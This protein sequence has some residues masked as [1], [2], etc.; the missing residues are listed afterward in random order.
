M[1]N[2]NI[3]LKGICFCDNHRLSDHG[4]VSPMMAMKHIS[5]RYILAV[6]VFTAFALADAHPAR[7]ATRYVDNAAN[8]SNNGTSWTNAWTSL[9]AITGVT[10]GDTVYIS[11]GT[12]SKTYS[13]NWTLSPGSSGSNRVTY[14]IGQE[15]G[16]IGTA[17]FSGIITLGNYTVLDGEYSG[18]RRFQLDNEVRGY[19][20]HYTKVT[21]CTVNA[22]WNYNGD[23][24]YFEISYCYWNTLD[25]DHAI[26]FNGPTQ[27]TW[28]ANSIHHNTFRLAHDTDGSGYGTDGLQNLSSTSIY[29]NTFEGVLKAGA[30]GN[31]QDG[32]QTGENYIK[33]YNNT[34]INITNYAFFFEGS[35]GAHDVQVYN[36]VF[37]FTET[38]LSGGYQ[39][40]IA[41]GEG[42]AC[43][44]APG[45]YTNFIVANNTV[46]DK[47]GLGI[48]LI[49][50]GQ[51]GCSDSWD[52]STIVRNNFVYS[53]SGQGIDLDS[54]IPTSA[55]NKSSSSGATN[56]F[57]D[58]ANNDFHLKSTDTVLKDQGVNTVSSYFST[59]KDG[60]SRPQGSVWDIGAYEF[61]A[62]SSDTTPP[63][64]SI[65]SPTSGSIVSGTITVS[66]NASDNVGVT[67]VQFKLDGSNLGA[68][69][70]SS[71]YSITWNTASA[72]NGS[73][74]L[75]AVARD[76]SNNQTT[77]SGITVTVSNA[78]DTQA[79]T[80]PANLT[81]TAIS[82]TQINLSWTASTDNVGVT[83]Y[84]IYRCQG[85]GC[86]PSTQTG[87]SG[88]TSY[89]DTGL[90]GNTTY[91]YSVSAYDATG[92]ESAKSSTTFATTQT[93]P[94]IFSLGETSILSI[95]DSG[96]ANLLI[97][98]SATLSQ[99]GTIL[100]LSFYVTTAAGKLRLGVY[101]SSGPNGG[102]GVK[103]AETNEITPTT[104]WNTANVTTPVSLSPG[105]YWLA[106]LSNNNG[107]HFRRA[108]SGTA[109]YYS[110]TYGS[111][112]ATFSS[113]HTTISDHWSFYATLDATADTTP[114]MP[115]T[116]LKI[117]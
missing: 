76:T 98:Q 36:N 57:I 46:I 113:V 70:T 56:I 82:S 1:G 110:Y 55:S 67:G 18:N 59:D 40:G 21:Y 105:T 6:I 26:S 64:V 49:S 12:T 116:G 37:L 84:K 5:L 78:L 9:G 103:K 63:T 54:R 27:L 47:V 35:G 16:H 94:P 104:G 117:N 30:R 106:Y 114:P 101:D 86:T 2:S 71:P 39:C 15:S 60:V 7:A 99:M 74:T 31:H 58:Y 109:K 14:K 61:V 32:V 77:S 107:L 115:P 88:T 52:S 51:S 43:Q 42:W 102:P 4:L 8:G 11:G 91:V 68:E 111:L 81:T 34:C 96:N 23:A 89:S 19:D 28:D 33:F 75:T 10:G 25:D 22:S 87:T 29:N 79:P 48:P 85:S 97:S 53:I 92:N 3:A 45:T 65:T 73:H 41:I 66:A 93:P 112:P 108:G 24:Q 83:G 44:G 20:K 72:S 95:D 80:V 38:Q 13:G 62:G 17:I 50:V 100:S 69:N 90:S